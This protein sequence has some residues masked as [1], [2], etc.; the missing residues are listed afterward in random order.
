MKKSDLDSSTTLSVRGPQLIPEGAFF[1]P[2]EGFEAPRDLGFLLLLRFTLLA[3][4]AAL[5]PL[6][7][8]NQLAQKPLYRWSVFSETGDPVKSSSGIEINVHGSLKNLPK[9]LRLLVCSGNGGLE[10]ASNATVAALRKHKR[11]GGKIG[12]IC[13]G[14]ATLARAGLLK[15]RIFTMHWENQPGFVERFPELCPSPKRFEIDGDLWTCSG[16]AAATELM[17][18]VIHR[19]FGRDFAIIVSD[20]CLNGGAIETGAAQRSSLARALSTRNSKLIQV[21][22]EMHKNIEDPA[23]ME[24]LFD[25]AGVSR[26]QIERLFKQFLGETPMTIY[27]YIQLDRARSLLFETD[28]T[29]SEIASACGFNATSSFSQHYK[30]R[31]GRSPSAYFRKKDR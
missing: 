12:G 17:L 19:D 7:I 1:F 15:D 14:A 8:A 29:V 28:M 4:S 18:A 20:M 23:P 22:R 31:F 6:R 13:T 16:G 25:A 11:F 30:K 5:D 27:R 10:T 9:D 24:D 3:F 2:V 21:L 26:R